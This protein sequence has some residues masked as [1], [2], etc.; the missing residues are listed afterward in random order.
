MFRSSCCSRPPCLFPPLLLRPLCLFRP[1]LAPH[2]RPLPLNPRF[3]H[4]RG[5]CL[6]RR[7][8]MSAAKSR[9]LSAHTLMLCL[10]LMQTPVQAYARMY[11][12][13]CVYIYIHSIYICVCVYA[14]M[15]LCMFACAC[16][17]QSSYLQKAQ[18]DMQEN[19]K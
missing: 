13:I 6:P 1:L 11:E 8:L 5:V 12:C 2:L 9:F 10:T 3:T 14:S 17:C 4:L 7:R 15:Y 18:K 19:I 16:V